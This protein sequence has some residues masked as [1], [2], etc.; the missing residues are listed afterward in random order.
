MLGVS[1]LKKL[2]RE[3]DRGFKTAQGV[4]ASWEIYYISARRPA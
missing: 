1:D 2:I 3:Y 4:Y